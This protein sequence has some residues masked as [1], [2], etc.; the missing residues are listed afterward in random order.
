MEENAEAP[1]KE[2][3]PSRML[4][5]L[6][7]VPILFVNWICILYILIVKKEW[8]TGKFHAAQGAVLAIAYFALMLVV[9]ILAYLVLVF[10][11]VGNFIELGKTASETGG[12]SVADIFLPMYGSLFAA[13]LP[14]MLAQ[15]AY[16]IYSLYI[17]FKVFSGKNPRIPKI[18]KFAEGILSGL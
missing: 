16:V 11:F 13:F 14:L 1:K 6:C 8:K 7:Y 17:A 10:V 5:A 9:G 18:G 2:E 4:S 3:E 15:A 12:A